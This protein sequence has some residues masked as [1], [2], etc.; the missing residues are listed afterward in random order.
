MKRR[1]D[2]PTA[3]RAADAMIAAVRRCVRDA[4]ESALTRVTASAAFADIDPAEVT[5][6]DGADALCAMIETTPWADASQDWQRLERTPI[7]ERWKQ[8]RR[9]ALRKL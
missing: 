1:L 5:G 4:D 6:A 8:V 7:G 9:A 2:P 3:E